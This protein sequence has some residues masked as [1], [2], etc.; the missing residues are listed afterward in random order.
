MGLHDGVPS[1]RYPEDGLVHE[2]RPR[3]AARRGRP[4]ERGEA[5][6]RGPG[7]PDLE[8]RGRLG[9]DL[10]PHFEEELLFQIDDALGGAVYLALELGEPGRGIALPRDQGLAPDEVRRHRFEPALGDLEVVADDPVE[11]DAQRGY[12]R[13]SLLLLDIGV[14][15][16]V[17]AVLERAK[18]VELRVVARPDEVPLGRAGPKARP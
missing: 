11:P 5:V 3:V 8:H 6:A 9:L 13:R 14:E 1:L 10:F 16:L 2:A 12:A 17:G 7:A 4:G 18:P 15:D